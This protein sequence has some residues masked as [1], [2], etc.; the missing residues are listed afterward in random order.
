MA[1]C[2]KCDRQHCTGEDQLDRTFESWTDLADHLSE[3]TILF[4]VNNYV[5]IFPLYQKYRIQTEKRDA[6]HKKYQERQ[7]MFAKV[8]REMLDRD[9]QVA[10]EKQIE[11]RI[12]KKEE[13]KNG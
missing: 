10:L 13:A 1:R 11:E 6:H 12:A 8:A 2:T 5:K 4:A 9:E 3:E 7:K